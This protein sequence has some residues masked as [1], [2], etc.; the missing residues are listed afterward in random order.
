MFSEEKNKLGFFDLNS[1]QEAPFTFFQHEDWRGEE[2]EGQLAVDVAQTESELVII[3]AMAGTPPENLE[4]HLHN[5]LLTIRGERKSPMNL[6]VEHFYQ[7]CFWGKFSRTIILPE[8][9]KHELAK[10]QYKNGILIISLPK[11]NSN[12]EI[13]IMVIEE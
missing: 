11:S 1:S 12:N 9:V 5:D 3:A 10:A 2:A 6:A 8:H 7:E 4:I 13:P